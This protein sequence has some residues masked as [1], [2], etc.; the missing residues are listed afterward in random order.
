VAKANA[1]I[2]SLIEEIKTVRISLLER[3]KNTGIY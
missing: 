1:T 2:A 3:E